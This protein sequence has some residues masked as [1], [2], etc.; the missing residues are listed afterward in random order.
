MQPKKV[1]ETLAMIPVRIGEK[2]KASLEDAAKEMG[3]LS[4]AAL[5]RVLVRDFLQ[6]R[7]A[8]NKK[9]ANAR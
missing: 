3:L 8:D 5:V 7:A 9:A 4:T 1:R 2:D 6:S